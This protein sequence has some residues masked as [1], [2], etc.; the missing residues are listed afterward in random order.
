MEREEIRAAERLR[1]NSGPPGPARHWSMDRRVR[2]AAQPR[3]NQRFSRR[4]RR[5]SQSLGALAGTA[6][7][8]GLPGRIQHPDFQMTL[9][10]MKS[11]SRIP[12]H[13]NPGR[14]CVQ[15]VFGH[16]WMHAAGRTFDLPRGRCLLF[17]PGVIRDVEADEESGFLLTVARNEACTH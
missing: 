3:Q 14:I 13:Y 1:S 11:N 15:T 17:D 6:S 5:R 16:I 12:E 4:R 8:D 10:R 2:F 9:R 7:A